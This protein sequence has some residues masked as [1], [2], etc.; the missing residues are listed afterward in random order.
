MIQIAHSVPGLSCQQSIEQR[1]HSVRVSARLNTAQFA[2]HAANADSNSSKSLV[3]ELCDP[4]TQSELIRSEER[5]EH[6]LSQVNHV[7]VLSFIEI[8]VKKKCCEVCSCHGR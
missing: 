4:H 5:S 6:D 3:R 1:C 8:P 7:T 2:L